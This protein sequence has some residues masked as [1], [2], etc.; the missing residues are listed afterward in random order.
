MPTKIGRVEGFMPYDEWNNQALVVLQNSQE[1]V[2]QPDSFQTFIHLGD[3]V[4]IEFDD[5]DSVMNMRAI[6]K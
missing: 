6:E 4:E 3:F 1:V 5:N 2:V